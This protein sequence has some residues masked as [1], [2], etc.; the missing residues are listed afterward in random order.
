MNI[1]FMKFL[2][3]SPIYNAV[4]I[5]I[6]YNNKLK[7]I[8]FIYKLLT[9]LIKLFSIFNLIVI[10][11][12]LIH[13]TEF[14]YDDFIN[15]FNFVYLHLLD[16]YNTF[17]KYVISKIENII[18]NNI[19]IN[20]Q[21]LDESNSKTDEI[22]Q[23]NSN[24]TFYYLGG[25]IILLASGVII[26]IYR[27]DIT[28]LFV[29]SGASSYYYSI[30][31]YILGTNDNPFRDFPDNNTDTPPIDLDDLRDLNSNVSPTSSSSSSSSP[32]GPDNDQW[33]EPSISRFKK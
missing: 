27:D 14:Q 17:I 5:I 3:I 18:P 6:N 10:P 7:N 28:T 16:N 25:F 24:K 23:T 9:I 20:E 30:K 2:I 19:E 26:Y 32:I 21:V 12:T 22:V 11:Y 31:D 29:T 13:F 8:S 33:N 15:Y 4:K 1:K